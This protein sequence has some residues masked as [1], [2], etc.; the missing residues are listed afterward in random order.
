MKNLFILRQLVIFSLNRRRDLARIGVRFGT[1]MILAF[2][3]I[4]MTPH[5]V[6][7]AQEWRAPNRVLRVSAQPAGG[8]TKVSV[9]ADSPIW[10]AQNWQD[11]DGFH[12]VLPNTVAAESLKAIR[13]IKV[14]RVGTSLE[15]L[16]QT[17][18][19]STVNVQAEG[20]DITLVVDK[21]L[22]ALI[23]EGQARSEPG[24]F[25][26]QQHVGDPTYAQQSQGDA[27][28]MGT[29]SPVIDLSS[30]PQASSGEIAQTT[31]NGNQ[32]IVPSSTLPSQLL[33][34]RDGTTAPPA[35]KEV[36][37]QVED[38]GALAS[39]FSATSVFIVIT[40][41]LFGLLVSRR[42]RS[43]QAVAQAAEGAPEPDSEDA[44]W[45][46]TQTVEGRIRAQREAPTEALVKSNGAAVANTPSRQ[47]AVRTPVAG[48]TT[49]FGAYRIDQEVGKLILGQP[50][51]M[52][53]LAS[54]ASEDRRA[55]ET[56]LTKGVNAP[57]LDESA[58]SRA[59]GALEEYGFVAR[60]CATLLLAPDAFERTSAARSLGAIKSETA[61]PFLL[62]S[63]YDSESIVRN[64]AVLSIG[65][66][67]LPSA[68]GALLD[69]ARTH[70]DVPSALLSRTL[71]ACSVEGLDFFDAMP[72]EPSQLG[73]CNDLSVIDQITQLEPASSVE[74]LPE[75]SEDEQL[76]RALS[77]VGSV[78]VQERAEAL[79]ALAQF[80]VKSAVEAITRLV[81]HE[82]E[83][84]L[85]AVAIFSLGAIDH[86]SVFAPIL[87]GMADES[88]E[89]RAAAARALNRLS[90]DRADAYVRV[91]ETSD[92]ETITNVARACIQA[93]IVS[94]NVDR[95]A[96]SD[97][98]QAYETFSLIYLLA[99]ANMND[100]IL[101]VI[102]D[103]PNTDV[104]LKAVHL[105]AATGQPG[106]FEHLRQLAVREGVS[107]EV[108]TA[109]LEAMY[110]LDQK[111]KRQEKETVEAS[112]ADF[113]PHFET[114]ESETANL[115][116]EL[117]FAFAFEPASESD[118]QPSSEAEVQQDLDDLEM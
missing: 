98:R 66:L 74:E 36:T 37:V 9:T 93:G 48:P 104:R 51:R 97:Y 70:P 65:E 43:R 7:Q 99:K 79:K 27:M 8:G 49:L 61:L 17:K 22:E 118:K 31:S 105:L 33:P 103:H 115:D 102:V 116:D 46:E 108:K 4:S 107:E 25:E 20:N 106:I 76:N 85:R 101:N 3:L 58:R 92:E 18:P 114:P 81:R 90:F 1:A 67:K 29:S 91:I 45:V 110:N 35:G 23:P 80:Q 84:N 112:E 83:P 5:L 69:I 44:E 2:V 55:I 32:Q 39:V 78:D 41:G 77:M 42:L 11:G 57:D 111:A 86:E 109:L 62:E 10:K 30:T 13:G 100:P 87:I 14:S 60:Q 73:T 56:S 113:E 26:Q 28:P 95:L 16:F 94:Q 53:V 24:S 38:E 63:L 12:L 50:H 59:R 96:S 21:K 54:R 34:E 6:S 72:I 64:Q 71:S 47:S 88:R 89:V 68:I 82:S 15:V 75:H 19:G 117:G 52:D 40:L